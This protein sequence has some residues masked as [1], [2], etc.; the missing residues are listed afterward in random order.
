MRILP[1]IYPS[2]ILSKIRELIMTKNI[3]DLNTTIIFIHNKMNFSEFNIMG[4]YLY[5]NH[6]D[7][8]IFLN[9]EEYKNPNISKQFF[10]HSD[11]NIIIPK[12]KRIINS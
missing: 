2:Y 9:A 4:A 10:S 6:F 1:Q 3:K 11:L 5:L 12:I 7:N 8:C